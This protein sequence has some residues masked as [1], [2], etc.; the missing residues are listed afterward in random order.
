M[1]R[2][3][4]LYGGEPHIGKSAVAVNLALL[5]ARAGRRTCIGHCDEGWPIATWLGEPSVPGHRSTGRQGLDLVLWRADDASGCPAID[6][7]DADLAL[8]DI[9]AEHGEAALPLLRMADEVIL[10]ARAGKD[11]LGHVA[12]DLGVVTALLAENDV[13]LRVRGLLLTLGDRSL[14]WFERLLVQVER[15]FPLEVFPYCVPRAEGKQD[16]NDLVV[17]SAATGR[18]ARAYVELAMEVL[19]HDG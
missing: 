14:E 6:E 2:T 12:R 3:I 16:A 13:D 8:F 17:E 11:S 10:V 7:I 4:A 19:D 9:P 5:A 1:V 15:A 18:R